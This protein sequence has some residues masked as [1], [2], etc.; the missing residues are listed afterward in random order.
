MAPKT[1]M[2][3]RS[4]KERDQCWRSSKSEICLKTNRYALCVCQH[5]PGVCV[6]QQESLWR[7]KK[8]CFRVWSA[9]EKTVQHNAWI[10]SKRMQRSEMGIWLHEEYFSWRRWRK[11][12]EKGA[13]AWG[14][15][16]L[17]LAVS[18]LEAQWVEA[19]TCCLRHQYTAGALP[20]GRSAYWKKHVSDPM[21][22]TF[23]FETVLHTSL[24]VWW[25]GHCLQVSL[26]TKIVKMISV[27]SWIK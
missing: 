9:G 6:E 21:Y 13:Q 1:G 8:G 22:I 27:T 23:P 7:W 3:D 2:S 12:M 14:M 20:W 17:L 10:V 16:K 26:S 11:H 15:E 4:A 19:E 18:W 25:M 5:C 24:S